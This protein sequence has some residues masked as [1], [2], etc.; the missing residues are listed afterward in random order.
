MLNHIKGPGVNGFMTRGKITVDK[1]FG[2]KGMMM[3]M[4]Q[5]IA[6]LCAT[7]ENFDLAFIEAMV[8]H[9]QTAVMMAQMATM[10]AEH[11]ELQTLAQTMID[12]QQREIA[13]MQAW[14]A[15]W[16]ASAMPAASPMP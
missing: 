1:V 7:T 9:H 8:P 10:R 6:D 15:A 3:D 16:S 11:P 4:E 5:E 14:R 13:Q 2:I 12:D